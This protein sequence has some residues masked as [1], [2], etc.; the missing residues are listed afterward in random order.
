MAILVTRFGFVIAGLYD[1]VIGVVFLFAGA[2][3]FE[4]AAVPAPNHWA[5]IQF[6][7]LLLIVFGTMF[8]TIAADPIAHRNLIPFGM[9][10]KL[11]Y[12]GLVAYYWVTAEC[13]MLFK[14]FAIIDGIMFFLF[15]LAYTQRFE[16]RDVSV[17]NK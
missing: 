2:S 15:L 14:P 1:L 4:A 13:P 6:A 16:S 9:L 12:T 8:F 10:L 17:A 3:I 11:S 5:Y 7:S